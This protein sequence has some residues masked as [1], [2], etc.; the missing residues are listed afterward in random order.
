MPDEEDEQNISNFLS[1]IEPPIVSEVQSHTALITWEPPPLSTTTDNAL[2]S[3]NTNDIR[4][5]I[6]LGDRGKDGKYKSI[7]KGTNLSLRVQ[8]LRAAQ[9]Y[10]VSIV[11]H[12]EEVQ[13]ETTDPVQFTTP[14]REP[15]TP[16]QP[17]LISKTKN[18]IQLRW[19][20]P[21]DNGAPIQ[22][23]LE[24]SGDAE[25]DFTEIVKTK[26]KQFT[27]NK[28][29]AA[30][31]YKFRLAAM[32]EFG[33]SDYSVP[34]G[35]LTDGYPPPQPLPPKIQNVTSSSIALQWQRRR[36]D[37]DFVLQFTCMGK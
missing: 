8:H 33:R 34:I 13:G 23:I 4:Y 2:N 5:E 36:E 17:K 6:F 26:S 21:N 24:M 25:H 15:D 30:T 37:G 3:L 32:N 20:A 19:N 29:Q 22:Y 28:L 14:G 27:V 9:E 7:F 10:Y 16:A 11:A 1:T 18:S 31:W 35:Y 12:Y